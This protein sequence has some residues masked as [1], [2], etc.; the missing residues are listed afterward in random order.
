M[1]VLALESSTSSAKAML[2]DTKEGVL[3]VATCP[4]PASVSADGISDTEQVHRMTMEVGAKV[5]RGR[6]V[7]AVALCGTWHNVA[8]LDEH[9]QPLGQTYS[10]N[11]LAPSESCA[12]MRRDAA[13]TDFL[14]QRTG[15]M[16]HT[17]YPRQHLLYLRDNGMSLAG[18]RFLS[19]G[20]YTFYQ[21][22]G[23]YCDS[24]STASGSGLVNVHTLEYDD[25][26][27]DLLGITAQQLPPI[28][29]YRD[30][31]PL[32]ARA[33][34]LLGITPGIPVVPAYPDGALNQIAS[35]AGQV[36]KMTLSLG[37]SAAIRLTVDHPVLPE[38]H[39]L[40]CY[41]GVTDWM[42][43]AATAGAGNCINWFVHDCLGDKWSFQ[44]FETAPET[45][46]PL[47]VF[48]PFLFGERCPGWQDNRRGGFV[49]V[50][51]HHTVA[52]L[53]RGM[54][55]GIL[56]NLYQCFE[57]LQELA[58][59]PDEILVSGGILNSPRWTQMLA[60]IFGQPLSCVPT[61]NAST[62]GAVILALH[63]AGAIDDVWSFRADHD[64]AVRV[65]PQMDRQPFYEDM[66]HRYLEWYPKMQ[67]DDTGL[68]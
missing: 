4:F 12:A 2:Y 29:T 47:P 61:L 5:A 31:R 1:I 41:H 32:T 8:L 6:E 59:R 67:L 66:Y 51:A 27:L 39:Q 55:A 16:P 28:V 40:W 21:L 11:Y 15:C 22:T 56:F 37:T 18:K 46:G 36:G 45:P 62:M 68:R 26:V 50:A 9:L 20:G 65:E 35:Y 52:D 49:E 53:Y 64:R 44:D 38:G 10:W 30:H 43:G 13:M 17:S 63:A 42:L 19:Q 34:E 58:G 60:D 3:D 25:S 14:Y 48:Q 23:T 33:A 24:V 7:A 57:S 54:Q